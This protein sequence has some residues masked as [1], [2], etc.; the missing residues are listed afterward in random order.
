MAEI[1]KNTEGQDWISINQIAS[2]L[3]EHKKIFTI[4]QLDQITNELERVGLIEKEAVSE[5]YSVRI[6]MGLI[7]RWIVTEP[8]F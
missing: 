6:P 2:S 1:A 7:K 4:E 3:A 5:N 8:Q